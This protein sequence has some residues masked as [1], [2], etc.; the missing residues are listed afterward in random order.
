MTLHMAEFYSHLYTADPAP[1]L[2]ALKMYLSEL[3]LPTLTND[4]A[5]SLETPFTLLELEE[6]LGLM[7]KR[8]SSGLD[9]LPPELFLELWDIVGALL[10][11]SFNYALDIG[12]F[13][14]DQN[15]SLISVLLKKD[16]PPL[17]C[18]SY[19]PISLITN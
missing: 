13:H 17:K 12:S 9:G 5:D 4:D 1:D 7:Q 8:K 15:T 14:R 6:A 3:K 16:K 18:G 2:A 19:R 11:N 10:L